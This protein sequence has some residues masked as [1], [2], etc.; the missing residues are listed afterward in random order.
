MAHTAGH[1]SPRPATYQDVLDAPPHHVA[2]ILSGELSVSP[3]PSGRHVSAASAM[4][5]EL[6]GPF[7]RGRGGPGGW[8]FL[9]EPELHFDHDVVVPD[10]AAWRRERME[11][12]DRAY[13]T[14]A[15]DWV[16]EVLSP[17]TAA[18][19][20]TQKLAIYAHAKVAHLWFVDPVLQTLEVFTL[21]IDGHWTLLS[22]HRGDEKVRAA[23][24]GELELEL[25]A[26]WTP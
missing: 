26:L 15:P 9:D 7:Q 21:A 8:V 5:G 4:Q 3:R 18:R 22:S 11:S 24:F 13:F 25:A 19:D 1:R 16:C 20:R 17:S 6:Y 14:V 12:L 10:L 2:E 23:P